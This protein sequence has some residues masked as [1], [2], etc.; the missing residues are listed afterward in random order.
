M[1]FR[2]I[3]LDAAELSRQEAAGAWTRVVAA[4]MHPGTLSR[5][6]WG[7]KHEE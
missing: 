3:T 7:M 5:T 6:W 1:Y 2:K 4:G